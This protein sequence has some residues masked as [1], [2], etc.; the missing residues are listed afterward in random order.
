MPRAAQFFQD[1]GSMI[2][3]LALIATLGVIIWYTIETRKLRKTTVKQTE[4]GLRPFVIISVFED[5]A[6]QPQRLVYKN[7][8][9]SPAI[10]VWTEPFDA[11]A[12]M[13][14]FMKY[15]LIE[16]GE[17]KDLNPQG[18]GKDVLSNGFVQAVQT[19]SF[20][21][22]ALDERNSELV[23]LLTIRYEN[24]EKASYQT[25]VKISR[26]GIEIQSTDKII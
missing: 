21:P 6:G 4:L 16:T 8:G 14:D 25:K 22:K 7:I 12:F 2:S 9:H 18:R 19:P 11:E 15:E 1:W 24:L 3:T 5:S 17:R 13:I 20:T 10:A 23:L 26:E